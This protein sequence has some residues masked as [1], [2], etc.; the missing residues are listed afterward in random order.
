MRSLVLCSKFAT[1]CTTPL[2]SAAVHDWG[3]VCMLE[4]WDDLGYITRKYLVTASL[5]D[6]LFA[7]PTFLIQ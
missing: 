3:A 1:P 2:G 7:A 4:G 5:S 6:M